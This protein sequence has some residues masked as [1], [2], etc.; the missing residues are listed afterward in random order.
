MG[1]GKQ[2]LDVSRN[3]DNELR[4]TKRSDI[5]PS[6]NNLA[7]EESDAA[8]RIDT[9]LEELSRGLE[10]A[11][12]IFKEKKEI[13]RR[14]L[15]ALVAKDRKI[16]EL[17]SRLARTEGA[18]KNISRTLY[19][20]EPIS[21]GR[22]PSTLDTRIS[23]IIP[24]KNAGENIRGLLGKIRSQKKVRDVEI[25]VID[26]GSTD[27][28]VAIAEGFGCRV[29]RIP[30]RE[31][32]HGATRNLGARE[33]H[34]EY[35][36]FTVQDA[37]PTSD[38]WLY[39]MVSPFVA[40]PEIAALSSKQFV[41]PEADLFSLWMNEAMYK[42]IGFVEDS[43]FTLSPSFDFANWKHVDS[44][45]KRY[46][47][48][49]DN[50]C[51]CVRRSVFDEIRFNPQ[52]NA[53]DMDFG[54]SLLEKRKKIGF[55]TSTGVYHWHE[56]G[57]EYVLKRHFIGTKATLYIM[58][59]ELHY[60]FNEHGIDWHSLAANIFSL[61][62]LVTIAIPD[63]NSS[64]P[65]LLDVATAFVSS[66]GRYMNASPDAISTALSLKTQSDG[67]G[68]KPRLLDLFGSAVPAPG[69]YTN[70]KKNFLIPKFMADIG[71]LVNFL[72]A[73]QFPAAERERDFV[74]CIQK[75]LAAIVGEALGIYYLEAETLG[76]LTDD[77]KRMDHV[78]AKGVCYY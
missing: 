11:S 4:E 50:V 75:T 54:V 51:S 61:H 1:V 33:A 30:E 28:T 70:Y 77:L 68:F 15:G 17:E 66:M 48:F 62:D 55:L 24:V 74:S 56:R 40:Y 36:V 45:I 19:H 21:A 16:A 27:G 58:K 10:C 42:S 60:F 26:S 13:S 6:I 59:N 32:N 2:R 38:Y 14:H 44:Q 49:F 69:E 25:I 3:P 22:R 12:L 64:G 43:I 9:R 39:A 72:S 20:V 23:V 53:E 67:E 63:A 41:R 7:A 29:I 5:H 73:R 37:L 52:I 57:P 35:L 65:R 47:S 8:G 18:L 71:N 78:L 34:G 31:F 76:H 46:L